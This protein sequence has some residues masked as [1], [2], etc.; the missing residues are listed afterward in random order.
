MGTLWSPNNGNGPGSLPPPTSNGIA[1]Q[2]PTSGGYKAGTMANSNTNSYSTKVGNSSSGVNGS[3]SASN[4]TLNSQRKYGGNSMRPF[5]V[6]NNNVSG[7]QINSQKEQEGRC[8]ANICGL[9]YK[10]SFSLYVLVF[11]EALYL[12]ICFTELKVMLM[13]LSFVK[14]L[15]VNCTV[16]KK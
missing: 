10:R 1:S 4:N 9:H 3:L 16:Q 15:T 11:K 14:I 12:P 7:K 6:K 8:R 13:V 2:P 5:V